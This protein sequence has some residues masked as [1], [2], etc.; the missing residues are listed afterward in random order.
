MCLRPPGR[1][2]GRGGG[3]TAA[4]YRGREEARIEITAGED[5]GTK[6]KSIIVMHNVLCS[7]ASA[8]SHNSRYLPGGSPMYCE[9]IFFACKFSCYPLYCPFYNVL[10]LYW[11]LKYFFPQKHG[12]PRWVPP[13]ADLGH[14]HRPPPVVCCHGRGRGLQEGIKGERHLL[15]KKISACLARNRT[16]ARRLTKMLPFLQ[17]PTRAV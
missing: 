4:R 11:A 9:T 12:L 16:K 10:L 5:F 2:E 6:Q 7:K 15:G 14:R 1:K 8:G 13:P 17:I 3:E